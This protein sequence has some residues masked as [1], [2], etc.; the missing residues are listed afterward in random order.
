MKHLKLGERLLKELNK[1]FAPAT[2]LQLK[3]GGF[4]I[5]LDRFARTLKWDREGK[6]IKDHWER[7]GKAS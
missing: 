7:K 4:D 2:S 1:K 6:L 5:A 3:V